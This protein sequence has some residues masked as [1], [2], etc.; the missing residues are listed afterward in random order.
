M[1]TRA[2]LWV[3]LDRDAD[4]DA[5]WT[6]FSRSWTDMPGLISTSAPILN[7]SVTDKQWRRTRRRHRRPHL[8]RRLES[9]PRQSGRGEEGHWRDP[10]DRH[11]EMELP[12]EEPQVEIEVKMERPSSTA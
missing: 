4:Y 1:S 8:R 10:G 9:P 5:I 2:E 3:S 12:L 11:A 6:E 7:A